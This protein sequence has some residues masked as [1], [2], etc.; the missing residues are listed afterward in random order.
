MKI[1]KTTLF[2]PF[3]IIFQIANA[4]YFSYRSPVALLEI[5]TLLKK[6]SIDET[7]ILNKL[8]VHEINDESSLIQKRVQIKKNNLDINLH[9]FTHFHDS[10][11][12]VKALRLNT[13]NAKS[14]SFELKLSKIENGTQF[15]YYSKNHKYLA[16]PITNLKTN[17]IFKSIPIEDE[18]LVVLLVEPRYNNSQLTV[19]ALKSYR[20]SESAATFQGNSILINNSPNVSCFFPEWRYEANG[21]GKIYINGAACSGVLLNNESNN[22]IPYFL[23]ARHCLT[24][25]LY[26]PPAPTQSEIEKLDTSAFEFFFRTLD[27]GG[28]NYEQTYTTGDVGAS[29]LDSNF[30]TDHLLVQVNIALPPFVNYIGWD[31]T[32]YPSITSFAAYCISFPQDQGGIQK[33]ALGTAQLPGPDGSKFKFTPQ[34]GTLEKGSSGGPMFNTNHKVVGMY[35]YKSTYDAFGR[36]SEAWT[37]NGVGIKNYLSPTNLSSISSL[38]PM[39]IIGPTKLCYG[40][41]GTFT[42]PNLYPGESVT[43]SVSGNLQIVSSTNNSVLVSPIS[44]SASGK[45]TVTASYFTAGFTQSNYSELSVGVPDPSNV[46]VTNNTTGYSGSNPLP[47]CYFQ[48]NYIGVQA[49]NPAL[50]GNEAIDAQWTF[51]T[52]WMPNT[53]NGMY[54]QTMPYNQFGSNS[55]SV[56]VKNSCGWQTYPKGYGIIYPQCGGYYRYS[57]YPNPV[58]DIIYVEFEDTKEIKWYPETIDIVSLDISGRGDSKSMRTWTIS[59]TDNSL[60]VTR[61]LALNVEDLPSGKYVL[62]F[63]KKQEK[64]S[65]D[66]VDRIQIV[67]E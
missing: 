54:V 32:T 37:H 52:D 2:L 14:I 24:E 51:P 22:R 35:S 38:I 4:Q 42:M 43:W 15:Y 45:G 47:F 46:V 60:N 41:Q 48:N 12:S 5:D 1:F 61:K 7:K 57:V 62:V 29:Y 36:L 56:K 19:T 49:T 10:L 6:Y 34:I 66:K 20:F 59:Q 64:E 50:G 17:S 44:P 18:G 23:T 9:E 25:Y 16:G 27:C 65:Q 33:M 63:T 11:Y 53:A 8:Y 3:I 28:I 39:T 26:N 40:E 67:I 58:K 21:T 55:F 31:R 30:W 13:E